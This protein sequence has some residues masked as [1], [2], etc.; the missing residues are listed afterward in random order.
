MKNKIEDSMNAIL[1]RSEKINDRDLKIKLASE[2]L[3]KAAAL[4]ELA[5]LDNSSEAITII[6]EKI[7]K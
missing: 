5:K 4:L 6:M 3:N 1:N 2:C 7:S